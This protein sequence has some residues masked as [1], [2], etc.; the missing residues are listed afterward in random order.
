MKNK[1]KDYRN[2]TFQEAVEW[3]QKNVLPYDDVRKR[4]RSRQVA[5]LLYNAVADAS[6]YAHF[7]E[8]KIKE[9]ENANEKI[10]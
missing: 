2:M 1:D 8:Q 10:S 5:Y 6:K 9:L 3:V 4:V 7:L